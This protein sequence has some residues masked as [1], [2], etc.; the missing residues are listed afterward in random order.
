MGNY[1]TDLPQEVIVK[2]SQQF[3]DLELIHRCQSGDTEAFGQ[4]VTKY[5]IKIL[6]MIYGIVGNENDAW[7]LAQEAFLKAW[8]SI[9]QFEGRSS[10]YTWLYRITINVTVDSLRKR[11]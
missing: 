1:T 7:D 2:A 4:L 3:E 8:R 6:T 10:F 5:R 11:S 9:H